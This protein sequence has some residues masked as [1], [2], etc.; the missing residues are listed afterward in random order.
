MKSTPVS[1]ARIIVLSA[2]PPPP[3]TPTTLILAPSSF[4][5]SSMSPPLLF[6]ASRTSPDQVG[7]QK[8]EKLLEEPEHPLA[9]RRSVDREGTP[10]PRLL[11]PAK[12]QPHRGGMRRAGDHV[13]EPA[14][15]ARPPRGAGEPEDLLGELG[16]SRVRGRAASQHHARG[17][18][19]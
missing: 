13:C 2:L 16:N 8:S 11:E 6:A 14:P 12:E 18:Q 5:T 4:V 17:E 10:F 19:V 15:I 1:P 3:P 7:K 9:D